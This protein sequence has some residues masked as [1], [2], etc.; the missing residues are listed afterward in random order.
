MKLIK[1]SLKSSRSEYSRVLLSTIAA[2]GVLLVIAS[3]REIQR[4][5]HAATA[6]D[7]ASKVD[8][9]KACPKSD[10]DPL[11]VHQA[12]LQN[13]EGN[14][15]SRVAP[16][17]PEKRQV[18]PSNMEISKL[19]HQARHKVIPINEA[20]TELEINRGASHFMQNSGQSLTARFGEGGVR[21]GSSK[22]ES[23]QV[24][25]H[26]SGASAASTMQ[27]EASRMHIRHP[28][29]VVEWYEN[30]AKGIEHGFILGTRATDTGTRNIRVSMD[31]M[32][33]I[34]SGNDLIW[35]L[36]NGANAL[37]Y[38]GLQVKDATGSAI[39][40][41]M[42]AT[43]DGFTIQL[44]DAYAVYPVYV[45]PVITRV[46]AKLAPI[47]LG[48]GDA[49]DSFGNA[50][51]T[52]GQTLVVGAMQDNEDRGSVYIF[53]RIAGEWILK[54]KL[55]P[56][57]TSSRTKF[58]TSV[59]IQGNI[60]VVG[61]PGDALYGAGYIYEKA[62]DEW[63]LSA[64]V[65]KPQSNYAFEGDSIGCSV[66]VD[67]GVV[68]VGADGY[69]GGSPA[70]TGKGYVFVFEKVSGVWTQ[71]V[72][73]EDPAGT[74]NDEY[75]AAISIKN[76]YAYIGKPGR[77]AGEVLIYK[78]GGSS[79][80][81]VTRLYGVSTGDRFGECLAT[82]GSALAVGAPLDDTALGANAGS[83]RVFR[84]SA[85]AWVSEGTLTATDAASQ[86]RFGTSVAI[87]KSRLLIG[88]VR[89]YKS[90]GCAYIFEK[91]TK[92]S[93]KKHRKTTKWRQ[94]T[95]LI[96]YNTST[97]GRSGHCVALV[98]NTV[99]VGAYHSGTY[100]HAYAGIVNEYRLKSGVWKYTDLITAGDSGFYMNFGSALDMDGQRI[101]VGVP[102]DTSPYGESTG[103]VYVFVKIS[104]EWQIE[105]VL[106]D[107]S[108][109][110]VEYFG[111]AVEIQGDCLMVGNPQDVKMSTT[112]GDL[113]LY[114]FGSVTCFR[115]STSGWT[116]EAKMRPTIPSASSSDQFGSSISLRG[117]TILIGASQYTTATTSPGGTSYNT[118]GAGFLFSKVNGTWVQQ[119]RLMVK[120]SKSYW[121][122]GASVALG[123]G[124]LFMSAPQH[125]DANYHYGR[126]FEFTGSGTT[127]KAGSSIG[128][129]A[130]EGNET[131]G[132]SIALD[133]DCLLV[134]S[135][136]D[137]AGSG[138]NARVFRRSGSTW[139]QEATLV[140]PDAADGRV[141]TFGVHVALKGDLAL[142]S[143][144][145]DYVL[146]QP[147]GGSIQVFRKQGGAW[148]PTQKLI[149]PDASYYA[150]FGTPIVT[151]GTF[152]LTAATNETIANPLT[153]DITDYR[154]SVYLFE[155]GEAYRTL[156]VIRQDNFSDELTFL[157]RA[158]HTLSFPWTVVGG[159]NFPEKLILRN[160][161]VAPIS[162][163]S[164][165]IEGP[166]A[167]QFF[168]QHPSVT[169]IPTTLAPGAEVI[170]YLYFSPTVS[171]VNKSASFR[172]TNDDGVGDYQISIGGL[173]NTKPQN[174][175]G[176]YT[177]FAGQPVVIFARDLAMDP[178]GH[179]FVLNSGSTPSQGGTMTASGNK[180]TFVPNTGFTGNIT[181]W[182]YITDE[183]GAYNQIVNTM[184]VLAAPA[185]GDAAAA[186]QPIKRL[187]ANTL[188]VLLKGESGVTYQIQRSFDLQTWETLGSAAPVAS[189]DLMFM[190]YQNAQPSAYYRL[191]K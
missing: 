134:G 187:N 50:I 47:N 131:F 184:T 37:A 170:V 135:L 8:G 39:T 117:N 169:G 106:M 104:G 140:A 44:Q 4:V 55:N 173:A 12:P 25:L 123:D 9:S 81:Y 2:C 113:T 167:S 23:W 129:S 41:E 178:D 105:A 185:A 162:G 158:G 161:G 77:K 148:S 45:D 21:L 83:V 61:S 82:D 87:E 63:T 121:K 142:V 174:T 153:G 128:P 191:M 34:Q 86:A 125:Y 154:G 177:C 133:G 147:S 20:A 68:M 157:P 79:W 120:G 182:Y 43:G 84:K 67:N 175:G 3:R 166:E 49:G 188:G 38:S 60:L 130:W 151:D 89:G 112:P 180:L 40:A 127:W 80:T 150:N 149:A 13:A 11:I 85:E 69:T 137:N 103:S 102:R 143:D 22:G 6:R 108:P 99:W 59:A 181:F 19:L 126:I 168:Y 92:W 27:P 7:F 32:V 186:A 98:G 57:G 15:P 33:A 94:K 176:I 51:S 1:R 74:T 109:T 155:L 132:S 163:I 10:A 62:A 141:H 93:Q 119:A 152:V 156:E 118:P 101:V 75:G 183:Y 144:P 165:T 72:R 107:N 159:S 18:A 115:R 71:Q 138:Q 171:G 146:G 160:N 65:S 122:V 29:G 164:I 36:P 48:D 88:A 31:G 17:A 179:S 76:G 110:T 28:D 24:A 26:Y 116:A 54:S 42:H 96:P 100:A 56:T 5:D 16:P 114:R 53:S 124:R 58:G 172:I 35:S 70:V 78:K 46:T 136:A 66:A 14:S 73:L 145:S 190:D 91:T 64:K 30:S 97:D 189:G 90:F 95:R 139:Q 52:D 111:S